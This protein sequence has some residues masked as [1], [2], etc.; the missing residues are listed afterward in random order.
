MLSGNAASWL[1]SSRSSRSTANLP[2][3]SGSSVSR[4]SL[5]FKLSRAARPP[6]PGDNAT[7][8]FARRSK[9]VKFTSL[10]SAGGSD[11]K[12]F[13]PNDK[14]SNGNEPSRSG[15]DAKPLS[16]KSNSSA[17]ESWSKFATPARR[18]I[19]ASNLASTG[20][21]RMM[22]VITSEFGSSAGTSNGSLSC[23]KPAAPLDTNRICC[24]GI[25]NEEATFF[26]ASRTTMM[27]EKSPGTTLPLINRKSGTTLIMQRL[28]SS[29]ARAWKEG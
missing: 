28:V 6:T 29:R 9:R 26:R 20:S 19:F 7:S 24:H 4:F 1:P 12:R 25:P 17:H 22:T 15:N 27:P 23:S 3:S 11:F 2:S 5:N 14:R 10:S 21:G 8:P 18:A 16:D 13:A